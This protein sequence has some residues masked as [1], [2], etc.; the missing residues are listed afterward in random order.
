MTRE[1]YL[2]NKEKVKAA[3]KEWRKN[4]PDKVAA[5]SKRYKETHPDRVKDRMDSWRERNEQHEKDYRKENA[6]K[7]NQ[8]GQVWRAENLEHVRKKNLDHYYKNS[9]RYREYRKANAQSIGDRV[10]GWK[11]DKLRTDPLFKL[12]CNLRKNACRALKTKGFTKSCKT[13]DILGCSFEDFKKW[14]ESKFETWMTWENYGLYN[15]SPNYG[16]D[17]D[18]VIPLSVGETK[19]EM[20]ALNYYTN[21]QPLCSHQNRYIKRDIV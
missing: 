9:E 18:H 20:E 21:Y 14:I 7:I 19:A 1:Y 11:K 2:K 17:L 8:Y 16:W 12:A 10:R 5:I 3:N 15:G 4:N 13:R 6:D